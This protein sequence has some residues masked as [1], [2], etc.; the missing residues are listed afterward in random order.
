[1]RHITTGR[2]GAVM[3][4]D[5]K[6]YKN[7]LLYLVRG[8]DEGRPAWYYLLVKDRTRL[9]MLQSRHQRGETHIALEEY[10][11]IVASGWGNHPPDHVRAEMETLY[12]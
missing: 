11:N 6:Q 7:K 2:E 8:E 9:M 10:G 5:S 3:R 12:A 1:M 4:M